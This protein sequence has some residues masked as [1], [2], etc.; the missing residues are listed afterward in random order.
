MKSS[1][2][3]NPFLAERQI[4]AD[5]ARSDQMIDELGAAA[6]SA[7]AKIRASFGLEPDQ[8][9]ADKFAGRVREK[10]EATS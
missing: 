2:S 6:A 1:R 10:G 7:R 8:I 3:D 9:E 4:H 5:R